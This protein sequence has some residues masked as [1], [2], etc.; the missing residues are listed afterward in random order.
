MLAESDP[1]ATCLLAAEQFDQ[2]R[3]M[4][5]IL[6]ALEVLVA[7]DPARA[8]RAL[9]TF[10]TRWRDDDI[11]VDK[12]FR[13]QAMAW[14]DRPVERVEALLAH[15]A[16][17]L[18]RP[19]RVRALLGAFARGNPLGFHAPD[20]AG[21]RLLAGQIDALMKLNP[22][23]GARLA[24]LLAPW[25]RMAEPW[26]EAMR[27]QLERLARAEPPKDVYEV[28]NRSLANASMDAER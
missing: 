10:Y 9:K 6:G 16:F 24:T 18:R 27:E 1:G 28:L 21:Y 22:Q 26:R 11:A 13:V 3:H 15:E 17:D 7:H 5:E 4:T 20:G 2:A 23:M 8:E 12:W 19:N 25:R 14:R